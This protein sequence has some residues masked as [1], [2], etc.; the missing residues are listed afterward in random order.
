[1]LNALP[2]LGQ[3]IARESELTSISE[4]RERELIAL[5]Q[6]EASSEAFEELARG[7]GTALSS[8]MFRFRQ[9][10]SG[11]SAD[12]AW[13]EVLLAFYDLILESGGGEY[14]LSYFMPSMRFRLYGVLNASS[15]AISVPPR[16]MRR[17]REAQKAC[18]GEV[19]D[20]YR[21]AGEFGMSP[22]SLLMISE[23]LGSASLDVLGEAV[24][25]QADT[26]SESGGSSTDEF[27]ALA[28]SAI[29]DDKEQSDVLWFYFSFD[30]PDMKRKRT[31]GDVAEL[32]D[33]GRSKVQ[34]IRSAALARIREVLLHAGPDEAV[35]AA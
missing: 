4:A 11:L 8:T 27:V 20:M 31:D 26:L 6:D 18:N 33:L 34:R 13:C 32:L 2:Q 22:S 23:L 3:T 5:V 14:R 7:Y 15:P 1:M 9:G 30:E 12:D 25:D 24:L 10:A 21:R 29:A 35:L 17:Y 28:F 19:L 16:T